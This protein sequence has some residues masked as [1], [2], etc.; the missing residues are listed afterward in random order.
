MSNR[1]QKVV[2]ISL[3]TVT[4]VLFV[5]N[6]WQA[7]RFNR[8]ERQLRSIEQ[9]HLGILEENK[10]LIVGIAGLRSPARV[11]D[12]ATDDLGLEPAA[13]DRVK[14]IRFERGW[15]EGE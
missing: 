8:I 7:Y 3:I 9:D 13:A 5:A 1:I 10:R 2:L 11:R 4:P 6:V 12:L 14:R 15:P